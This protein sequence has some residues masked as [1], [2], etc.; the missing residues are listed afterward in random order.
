MKKT[1][2]PCIAILII[3]L[4]LFLLLRS[5]TVLLRSCTVSNRQ[6]DEDDLEQYLDENNDD[7]NTV[8]DYLLN[9]NGRVHFEYDG[10]NFENWFDTELPNDVKS[11]IIRLKRHN[12]IIVMKSG[13]T[14]L[15]ELWHP[16]MRELSCGLAYSINGS[17]EP[18]VEY[19][20]EMT[21]LSEPGWYY[22]V[23]DFNTWRAEQD[24]A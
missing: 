13:N 15:I 17:D 11:A 19:A 10:I 23:D 21:P 8:L 12:R 20:T 3:V 5:C 14:I 18:V 16:F 4:P 24:P 7:F 1:I 6:P 9:Q 22:Y 2:Y